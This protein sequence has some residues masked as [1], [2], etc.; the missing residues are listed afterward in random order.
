MKLEIHCGVDEFLRQLPKKSE[1]V[2][3]TKYSAFKH[4]LKFEEYVY[5]S[6]F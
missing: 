2:R 5:I 1:I 6:G 4:V 3:I